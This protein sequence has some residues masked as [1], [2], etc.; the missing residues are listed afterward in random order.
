VTQSEHID[1][2]DTKLHVHHLKKARNVSDP[3]KRNAPE[4]L[5]T[6]CRDCHQKWEK[7]ADAGLVPELV[8]RKTIR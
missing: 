3:E 1:D 2:H 5:I 6:L 7:M 4:N 8:G